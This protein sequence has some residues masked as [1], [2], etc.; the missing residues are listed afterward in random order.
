[1]DFFFAAFV[2]S[3][4][5]K[6]FRVHSSAMRD[7]FSLASSHGQVIEKE[8]PISTW[9][10]CK[11]PANPLS[12]PTMCI[13]VYFLTWTISRNFIEM[14]HNYHEPTLE[15]NNELETQM[16]LPQKMI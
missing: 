1:M 2:T 12:L 6:P 4:A 11:A 10:E 5:L 3:P 16:H 9:D 15:D 14:G 8:F 13:L 7:Y